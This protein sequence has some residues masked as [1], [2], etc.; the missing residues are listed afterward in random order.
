M[1]ELKA[2]IQL[3]TVKKRVLGQHP[4]DPATGEEVPT[5]SNRERARRSLPSIGCL[6]K[7]HSD[8]LWRLL[9]D[10]YQGSPLDNSGG[11]GPSASATGAAGQQA[12]ANKDTKD[13]KD[14][15]GSGS[16]AAGD[17]SAN[18]SSASS[19]SSSSM[20]SKELLLTSSLQRYE[21]HWP[22]EG[23][24]PIKSCEK[25]AVPMDELLADN[26]WKFINLNHEV[27]GLV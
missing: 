8:T 20:A 15:S 24:T 21:R 6:L 9:C 23:E 16:A 2:Y 26:A 12:K 4:T 1:E 11:G 17:A 13:T 19:S 3:H 22:E 18:A 14:N 5:S 10:Y 25:L 7:E 27:S